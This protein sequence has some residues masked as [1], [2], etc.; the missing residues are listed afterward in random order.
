[1]YWVVQ[2]LQV[3]GAIQPIFCHRCSC[4]KQRN[5]VKILAYDSEKETHPKCNDDLSGPRADTTINVCR[6]LGERTAA[7]MDGKVNT[8]VSS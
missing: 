5:G 2:P 4:P 3:Q 1:M 6:V 7:S 8:V